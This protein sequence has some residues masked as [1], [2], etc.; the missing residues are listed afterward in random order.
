MSQ[1]WGV[2]RT[3]K[4]PAPGSRFPER[5]FWRE[6][7][8]PKTRG[9]GCART[10]ATRGAL[11]H[12]RR[13]CAPGWGRTETALEGAGILNPASIALQLQS[14]ALL[15][16][17]RARA[18]AAACGSCL[19]TR[20]STA[21]FRHMLISCSNYR[22]QSRRVGENLVSEKQVQKS[23][24]GESKEALVW[25]KVVGVFVSPALWA[26]LCSPGA[27]QEGW[28]GGPYEG[29]CFMPPISPLELGQSSLEL[30]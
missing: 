30:C 5:N 29:G 6:G 25:G 26:V 28:G 27:A 18:G 9:S 20:L 15:E 1:P 13:V 4:T 21:G 12:P 17:L 10:C 7:T 2:E 22:L 24:R 3:P 19:F 11:R 8:C 14:P 23:W 16:R